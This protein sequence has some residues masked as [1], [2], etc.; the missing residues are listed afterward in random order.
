[1]AKKIYKKTDLPLYDRSRGIHYQQVLTLSVDGIR[2]AWVPRF[3]VKATRAVSA[4]GI[5]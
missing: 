4:K 1:M 2:T 3:K 5:L